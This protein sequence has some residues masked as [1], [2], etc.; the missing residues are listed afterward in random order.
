[1]II[2]GNKM[3]FTESAIKQIADSLAEIAKQHGR[4]AD[5]VD[6]LG[7]NY[8]APAGPPGALE[9]IAIELGQMDTGGGTAVALDEVAAAIQNVADAIEKRRP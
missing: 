1:M 4:L 7:L 5:A 2:G 6:R 9:K 8:H 3:A